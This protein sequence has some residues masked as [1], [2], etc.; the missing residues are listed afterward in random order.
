[1]LK[2]KRLFIGILLVIMTLQLTYAEDLMQ[3]LLNGNHKFNIGYTESIHYTSYAAHFYGVLVGL[4]EMGWINSLEGIPYESGDDDTE[5]MWQWLVAQQPSDYLYFAPDVYTSYNG[6]VAEM[7]KAVQMVQESTD[8][9]LM[10]AMGTT[11]GRNVTQETPV[12]PVLVF[13]TSNAIASEII[14]SEIDSGKDNVWAHVDTKRYVKQVT[15]LHDVFQFKKLGIVYEDSLTGR[16]YADLDNVRA[17]CE[18]LGVELIERNV[19]ENKSSDDYDRYH[20]DMQEAFESISNEVD[21][22]YLTASNL[23]ASDLP[24]LFEPFYDMNIP[25]FSQLGGEEVE[26]AAIMSTAANYID[27]GRYGAQMVSQSLHGENPRYLYATY[28]DIPLIVFN[29]NIA[30]KIDY[31]PDFEI[32]L[33]AD[34]IY[35]DAEK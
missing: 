6:D 8:L 4:E 12:I 13:S 7:E 9:D 30:H 34:K 23:S 24:A 14:E 26:K 3:P 20:D 11:A 33:I 5:A 2:I 21:A 10:L 18:E 17:V 25:V 27:I 16:S 15:V 28:E 35:F 32:L 22:F 19:V 29:M 31:E 1:M